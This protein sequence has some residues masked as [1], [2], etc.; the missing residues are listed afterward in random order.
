MNLA[1]M[2]E[3]Y[4]PSKNSFKYEC[5]SIINTTILHLGSAR[6]GPRGLHVCCNRRRESRR[7]RLNYLGQE[8]TWITSAYSPMAI[9][10]HVVQHQSIKARKY[11]GGHECTRLSLATKILEKWKELQY[12]LFQRVILR[13]KQAKMD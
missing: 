8:V 5:V 13:I 1:V 10:S 2:L 3:K 6:F 11:S 12:H 9:T 7:R 4:Q